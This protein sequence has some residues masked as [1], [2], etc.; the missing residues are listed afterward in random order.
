MA[1]KVIQIPEIR[2]IL[3]CK[4]RN[5]EFWNPGIRNLNQGIRN[6]ANDWNP[7]SKLHLQE[8]GNPT[9]GIRNPRPGIQNPRLS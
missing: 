3:A 6:A 9:P 8:M 5:L 4:R 7:K 2:E 1:C